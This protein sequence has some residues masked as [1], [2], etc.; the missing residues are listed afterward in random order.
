LGQGWVR[1]GVRVRARRCASLLAP[2]E[3]IRDSWAD[4]SRRAWLGV[5]RGLGRGSGRASSV[6][7][8][9]VG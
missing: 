7:L 2:N 9:C 8:G 4:I 1:V 5:G 6:G 3:V